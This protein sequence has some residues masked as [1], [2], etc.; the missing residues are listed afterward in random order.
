MQIKKPSLL[1]SKGSLLRR[2]GLDRNGRVVVSVLRS[3]VS[4]RIFLVLSAGVLLTLNGLSLYGI[5]SQQEQY[6]ASLRRISSSIEIKG[7]LNSINE[8]LRVVINGYDPIKAK[9]VSFADGQQ[10]AYVAK[11]QESLYE[12]GKTIVNKDTKAQFD[13]IV[14]TMNLF[15]KSID[16]LKE[17]FALRDFNTKVVSVFFSDST[18]TNIFAN[19]YVDQMQALVGRL[20]KASEVIDAN[21]DAYVELELRDLGKTAEVL[22]RKQQIWL[23][24][25]LGALALLFFLGIA[26]SV[27]ALKQQGTR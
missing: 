18:Q 4:T 1:K 19:S 3:T 23:L 17:K 21:I 9:K 15:A 16:T 22:H 14:R 13:M 2:V 10:Y 7:Q 6:H 11:I 12:S 26:T 27:V 20:K 5:F 8:E 25:N 24:V